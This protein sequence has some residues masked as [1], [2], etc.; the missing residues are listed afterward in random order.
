[1]TVVDTGVL[2]AA[3]PSGRAVAA[4]NAITLEH[5]EAIVAAA[6]E[7][8][9]S[10]VL[11]LS[12]NAIAYHGTAVPITRALHALAEEAPV[13]IAVHLDHLTDPE[14]VASAVS[15]PLRPLIGS[16]M[17]DGGALPHAD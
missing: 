2:L 6:S 9:H 12:Q 15:G 7:S 3:T 5:A 11:Q 8:G 13:P 16:L 17:Y 14:L 4:V 1:M 10:L